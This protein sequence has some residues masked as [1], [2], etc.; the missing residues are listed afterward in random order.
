MKTL[1]LDQSFPR[2]NASF[3]SLA[4]EFSQLRK[5]LRWLAKLPAK[6]IKYSLKYY[7]KDWHWYF[8]S[9]KGF[10]K[11]KAKRHNNSFTVPDGA[12]RLSGQLLRL[13]KIGQVCLSGSSPYAHCEAKTAVIREWQNKFY[14][15]GEAETDRDH[16]AIGADMNKAQDATSGGEIR[17][18]PGLKNLKLKRMT[19]SAK[20]W[21]DSPGESIKGKPGLNRE[22][23]KTACSGSQQKLRCNA[24]GL[25]AAAPKMTRWMCH[26]FGHIDKGKRETQARFRYVSCG[27]LDNAAN[28]GASNILTLGTRA[29]GQERSSGCIP[30]KLSRRYSKAEAINHSL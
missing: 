19:S 10:L 18:F 9:D 8:K 13:R 7:A 6:P 5:Q 28:Y 3:F 23:L 14:A 22:I 27:N 4:K 25:I 30:A 17:R 26:L 16:E 29:I 12:F 2:P 1:Q 21:T 24:A 11:L 20:G 15:V